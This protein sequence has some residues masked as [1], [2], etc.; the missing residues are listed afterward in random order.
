MSK[1]NRKISLT[2]KELE[3]LMYESD[4]DYIPQDDEDN[5]N[6]SSD[7]DEEVIIIAGK[8]N[9]DNSDPEDEV[10]RPGPS[11]RP[12]NTSSTKKTT[13]P[14]IPWRFDDNFVPK[15]FNFDQSNS[16]IQNN[17]VIEE[18]SP[19]LAYFEHFVN[20]ILVATITKETNRYGNF[21]KN[22]NKPSFKNWSDRSIPEMYNFLGLCILMG[23]VEKPTLK[24]YWS[25][26][27]VIET[28]FFRNVCTRDTFLHTLYALHFVDNDNLDKD[29]PLRKIRPIVTATNKTFCESFYPFQDLAIDESLILW[30][31]RLAFKQYIPSKRH[32]FGV[33][34]F[35]ICDVETG[36]VQGYIIYTGGSTSI[37]RT[38]NLGI[39]GDIVATLMKNYLKKGHILYVD[40]WYSSPILFQY[41]FEN[42]T[43]T[44]GTVR[45]NRK[46]MPIF[47]PVEKGHC[48]SAHTDEL[49]ALKWCDKRNVHM[50]T[51]VYTGNQKETGNKHFQTGEPIIKPECIIQYNNKMG[52]VDKVDMQVSFV[53]CAR[54]S[55]KWYKKVFF[56]IIDLALYNALILYQVKTG[57]K[58][59]FSDFRLKLV[60]QLI[61]KYS[62]RPTAASSHPP[63]V[64]NPLRLSGRHFPTL[65]T[66][67]AAQG[68]RTQRRCHVCANTKLQKRK[69]K[70]VKYMCEE[71][72]V[73]LCVVPCFQE[74]HTKKKY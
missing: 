69:R 59:S 72:N 5:N 1:P 66:Q 18:S 41:L 70:D 29:D 4:S 46:G 17:V 50:L 20:E 15:Q 56:H 27:P 44:C 28:P 73:P 53:E 31:G 16:G 36:Y 3:A 7:S 63:T 61:E 39:S 58:P 54:K 33:K 24:D 49:L 45:P 60:T 21:L 34:L 25:R 12:T 26:N 11:N 47:G 51:S 13:T 9:T 65:V 14:S 8:E 23:L 57:N 40:N 22:Q 67:T 55:L 42:N 62:I 43:G 48:E 35:E 68:A 10:T 19:E 32:R 2:D 30:K 74:Y 38:D 64:D 52:A 71:C 37:E 6:Y